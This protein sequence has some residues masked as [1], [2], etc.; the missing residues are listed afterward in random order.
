MVMTAG[1][2]HPRPL[3]VSS[4]GEESTRRHPTRSDH[5]RTVATSGCRPTK[6]SRQVTNAAIAVEP[7]TVVAVDRSRD[8]RSHRSSLKCADSI[9]CW[10]PSNTMATVGSHPDPPRW[11]TAPKD[12]R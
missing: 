4:V 7:P 12:D 9:T 2:F 3:P 10:N 1:M 8:Q 11:L 5:H 6:T